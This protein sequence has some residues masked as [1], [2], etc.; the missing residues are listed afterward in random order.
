M[1]QQLLHYHVR[2]SSPVQR[3]K[4][5]QDTFARAS[6]RCLKVLLDSPELALRLT[7]LAS[8]QAWATQASL[9]EALKR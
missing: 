6:V 7:D 3:P 2:I 9:A 1:L 5:D 8:S 4:T